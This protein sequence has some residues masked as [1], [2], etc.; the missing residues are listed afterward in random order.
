MRT[1]TY[2]DIEILIDDYGTK[3]R[4]YIIRCW[5]KES[6]NGGVREIEEDEYNRISVMYVRQKKLTRILK[7]DINFII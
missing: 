2:A 3:H 6:Y 7:D 5:Q 4:Y 1:E